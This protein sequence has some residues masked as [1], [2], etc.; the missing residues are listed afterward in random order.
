MK[1]YILRH[2]ET[3][4]NKEGTIQ[5]WRDSALT[6]FGREQAAHAGEELA[7]LKPST[8]F[9]SDLGRVQQTLA[10]VKKQIG[11]IPVLLDWRLRE[12]NFGE[13]EGK[14]KTDFDMGDL[15]G[16]TE[17][18]KVKGFE[19][20]DVFTERITHFISDLLDFADDDESI[21]IITHN[22]VINRFAYLTDKDAYQWTEYTN[23][24]ILELELKSED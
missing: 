17:Y 13:A 9:A 22:G 20:M 14:Q 15:R 10:E 11:D 24:D 8:I 3:V 18:P 16:L 7:K 5:G 2:G 21:A 6:D 4:F 12:R 19:P 1:L 23:G